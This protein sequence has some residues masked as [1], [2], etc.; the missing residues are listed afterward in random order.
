M[1]LVSIDD[2]LKQLESGD[3]ETREGALQ[4]LHGHALRLKEP[5][6]NDRLGLR[7]IR[8]LIKKAPSDLGDLDAPSTL[9]LAD[10][11]RIMLAVDNPVYFHQALTAGLLDALDKIWASYYIHSQLGTDQEP[12]GDEDHEQEHLDNA[13]LKQADLKVT[14]LLEFLKKK[15]VWLELYQFLGN[16]QW[17][18]AHEET[19]DPTFLVNAVRAEGMLY[20][21]LFAFHNENG[22]TKK[23]NKTNA[24][25]PD[26][27]KLMR[28]MVRTPRPRV[29]AH[30][31][32]FRTHPSGH[33]HRGRHGRIQP[34]LRGNAPSA[35]EH[36]EAGKRPSGAIPKVERSPQ[37]GLVRTPRYCAL[38]SL[39]PDT[40]TTCEH[41]PRASPECA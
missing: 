28:S 17:P 23:M 38:L 34:K 21:L 3:K 18:V 9:H 7:F 29:T 36:P 19:K 32:T 6:R 37:I 24:N 1:S 13:K 5:E 31:S 2:L 4:E 12:G 25:I 10:L 22:Y 14:E 33:A 20:G 16:G 11:L 40:S 41:A 30:I 39:F 8:A 15:Y 27:G 35:C 26:L